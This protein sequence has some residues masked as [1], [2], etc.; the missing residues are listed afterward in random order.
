MIAVGT[1]EDELSDLKKGYDHGSFEYGDPNIS[2]RHVVSSHFQKI[3]RNNRHGIYI[4]RQKST[5]GVLY[6]GKSGTI[7]PNGYFKGQDIPGRLKNV[8]NGDIPADEWF[9]NL[10]NEKGQ[11]VIEYVF[12]PLTPKSPTLIESLLLQAYFNENK[13][14]PYRNNSF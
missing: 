1:F 7:N 8:K 11:L 4:V 3:Q 14:L 9:K 2:F 12:F 10:V 6:I 5:G 13:S